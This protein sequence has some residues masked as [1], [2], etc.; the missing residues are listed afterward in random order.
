MTHSPFPPFSFTS[1]K[2]GGIFFFA[3]VE[4]T[5]AAY[6]PHAAPHLFCPLLNISVVNVLNKL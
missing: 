5:G 6:D 4:H 2:R 1:L 3:V